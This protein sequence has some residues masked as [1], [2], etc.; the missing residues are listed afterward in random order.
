MAEES[1]PKN[2]YKPV[3]LKRIKFLVGTEVYLRTDPKQHKRIVTGVI[4]KPGGYEYEVKYSVYEPTLHYDI[5]ISEE[6]DNELYAQSLL[7]GT[8]DDE[9]DDEDA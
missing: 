4:V 3:T 9:D 1:S 2:E 6:R 5:E 7:H 8:K